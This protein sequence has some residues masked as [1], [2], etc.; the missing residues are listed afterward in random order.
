[1]YEIDK[2]GTLK[3][4]ASFEINQQDGYNLELIK[5]YKNEFYLSAIASRYNKSPKMIRFEINRIEGR[6]VQQFISDIPGTTIGFEKGSLAYNQ[7]PNSSFVI[8]YYNNF[9]RLVSLPI[10]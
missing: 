3:F 6:I 10:L 1:M 5:Q 2:T 7:I 4:Y 8:N 9:Y